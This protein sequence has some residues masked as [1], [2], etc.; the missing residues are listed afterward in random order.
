[1][2]TKQQIESK[3]IRDFEM[4]VFRATDHKLKLALEYNLELLREGKPLVSSLAELGEEFKERVAQHIILP[5]KS[6]AKPPVQRYCEDCKTPIKIP[7]KHRFCSECK[8]LRNNT[9][10]RKYYANNKALFGEKQKVFYKNNKERIRNTAKKFYENHKEDIINKGKL[11]YREHK[12]EIL[13]KM[14]EKRQI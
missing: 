8:R 12:E 3:E 7:N 13:R 9:Q 1:M 14:K 5:R 2:K 4:A 11:Y 10:N 6:Q